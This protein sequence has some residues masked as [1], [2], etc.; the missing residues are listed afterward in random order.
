MRLPFALLNLNEKYMLKEAPVSLQIRIKDHAITRDFFVNKLGL[1]HIDLGPKVPAMY[2]AGD[3]TMIVA[4][5]G[6]PTHPE[7]T[8][9]MFLVKDVEAE[10]RELQG[11]GVKFEEY[12]MPDL[13]TVNGIAT[14]DEQKSAWFK[15]PDGYIFALMT[16]PATKT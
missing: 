10:V 14:W 6:E 4:Y 3:G 8:V 5:S 9:G 16:A 13:K 15:D 1:K 7:H 11:K 12:D 2:E